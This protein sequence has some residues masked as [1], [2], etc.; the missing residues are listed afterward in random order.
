MTTPAHLY[1]TPA[2]KDATFEFFS[3]IDNQVGINRLLID[4][5][6]SGLQS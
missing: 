5:R 2:T 3:L 6:N 4:N 1:S